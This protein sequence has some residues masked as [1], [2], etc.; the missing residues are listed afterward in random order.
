MKE[1]PLEYSER[2]KTLLGNEYD[3]YVEALSN[4]PVRGFRVNTDKISL[5]DFAA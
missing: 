5:E 4:S 3:E 2:M 1:L